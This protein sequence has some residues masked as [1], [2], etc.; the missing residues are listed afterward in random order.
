KDFRVNSDDEMS[1]VLKEARKNRAL[2]TLNHPF[3]SNTGWEW[4]WN[5]DYDFVEVWNGPW[6]EDNQKAVTWW[7]EQLTKGNKLVAIGGSDTHRPDFVKHGMPTTWV[8]TN[9]ATQ[10]G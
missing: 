7:Q 8:Y 1:I 3:C 9:T 5:I 6:R 2:I 4:D 10:E